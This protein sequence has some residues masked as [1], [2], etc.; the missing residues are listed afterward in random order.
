MGK[1]AKIAAVAVAIGVMGGCALE[2]YKT[3]T[4][5]VTEGLYKKSSEAVKIPLRCFYNWATETGG[6]PR[7]TGEAEQTIK[8]G[9]ENALQ[10]QSNQVP[11]LESNVRS[12]VGDTNVLVK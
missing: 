6:S 12:A 10:H 4:I 5:D 9:I 2:R 11:N 7:A 1:Y 8:G 3:Q